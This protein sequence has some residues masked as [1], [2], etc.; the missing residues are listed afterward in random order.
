M[1]DEDGRGVRLLLSGAHHLDD[2]CLDGHVQGSRRL[3][4]D[5][6]RGVVRHRHRDHRPLSHAAGELVRVLVEAAVWKGHA[7]DLEQAHRPLAGLLVVDVGIVR[8]DRLGDLIADREHGIERGHR[9]LEDHRDLGAPNRLELPL[10][11][12]Q[13]IAALEERLPAHDP[14]RRHGNQAEHRHDRYAL[15]GPDSPTTPS[16]SPGLRS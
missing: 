10:R 5:E 4:G 14:A 16:V 7:D 1:R 9:V 12:G 15:P 11:Q 6:N 8:R 3:V 13:E 2:L